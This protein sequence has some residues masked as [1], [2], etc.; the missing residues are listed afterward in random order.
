MDLPAQAPCASEAAR[1]GARRTAM[2]IPARTPIGGLEPRIPTRR[3]LEPLEVK[4]FGTER[5]RFFLWP[6]SKAHTKPGKYLLCRPE[7][8]QLKRR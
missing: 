5:F 3:S 1:A 4:E 6:R 8:P 7:C 2:A